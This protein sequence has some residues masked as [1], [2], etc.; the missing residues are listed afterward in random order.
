MV[1]SIAICVVS[2]FLD[3][4][5]VDS[6]AVLL[7]LFEGDTFNAS[8]LVLSPLLLKLQSLLLSHSLLLDLLNVFSDLGLLAELSCSSFGVD[9]LLTI[10]LLEDFSLDFGLVASHVLSSNLI[11][12]LCDVL[13]VLRSFQCMDLTFSDIF[14]LRSLALCL[15]DISGLIRDQLSHNHFDSKQDMLDKH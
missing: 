8:G 1:D 13:E 14:D 3:S 15:N 9:F 5:Q 6:T 12:K 4:L 10:M 11:H 7:E 2:D